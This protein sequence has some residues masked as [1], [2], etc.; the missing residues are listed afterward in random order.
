MSPWISVRGRDANLAYIALTIASLFGLASQESN[1]LRIDPELTSNGRLHV[2]LGRSSAGF[3]IGSDGLTLSSAQTSQ[4]S[5]A[6]LCHG[7]IWRCPCQKSSGRCTPSW[8]HQSVHPSGAVIT[9]NQSQKRKCDHRFLD[10]LSS[11]GAVLRP[12]ALLVAL[13]TLD[14]VIKPHA[15][16]AANLGGS[17]TQERVLGL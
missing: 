6:S 15:G 13:E 8:W 16:V 9:S 10:C 2:S 17:A 14:P 3:R 4:P 5:P 7:P 11:D 12:E 1:L